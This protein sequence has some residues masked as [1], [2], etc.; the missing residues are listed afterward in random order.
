MHIFSICSTRTFFLCLP[1]SFLNP[2][3]NKFPERIN[4]SERFTTRPVY[5]Y[6]TFIQTI[7]NGS[8]MILGYIDSLDCDDLQFLER[9]ADIWI[10]F[11]NAIV[12]KFEL[13]FRNLSDLRINTIVLLRFRTALNASAK[14]NTIIPR[15]GIVTD[16]PEISKDVGLKI[17][18]MLALLITLACSQIT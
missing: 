17:K 12:P 14:T 4:I 11:Y 5:N 3:V 6:E 2:T 1:F 9:L 8:N 13:I 10:H 18:Q 16:N 7:S 15:I